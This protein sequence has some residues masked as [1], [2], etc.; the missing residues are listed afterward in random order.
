MGRKKINPLDGVSAVRAVLLGDAE[1]SPSNPQFALAVRYLLQS[2]ADLRPGNAV[3]V[4][5]PPLGAVQCVEGPKHTRGTPPNVI[6]MSP[7]VWFD[8]ATDLTTWQE[9]VAAG[10]ISASGTRADLAEMLPLFRS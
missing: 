1:R 7:E 10:R 2:L 5:V 8:L 4:R 6:E 3:E 9:E